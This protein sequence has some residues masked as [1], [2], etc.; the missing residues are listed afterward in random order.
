[1]KEDGV[2]RAVAFT[3]YPQYS[4]TTTGSS[5][6]ELWAQTKSLGL[7]DKIQWSVIDRWFSHPDFIKTVAKKVKQGLDMFP[8]DADREDAVILFR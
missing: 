1:M 2:Q 8:S 6:N 4:C 7:E 3:Q 5:L